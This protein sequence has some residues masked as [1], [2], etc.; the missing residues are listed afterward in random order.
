MVSRRIL[1]AR[2]LPAL[3][4]ATLI[5]P[6]ATAIQLG[7][8]LNVHDPSTISKE[9][10]R[11]YVYGTGAVNAPIQLKVFGQLHHLAKRPQRLQRYTRLGSEEVGSPQ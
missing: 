3:L 2:R 10:S 9:G 6:T 1:Q 8:V 5:C 7:G 11:Y 4:L